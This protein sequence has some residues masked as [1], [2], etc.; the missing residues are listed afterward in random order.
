MKTISCALRGRGGASG[1]KDSWHLVLEVGGDCAF[2]ITTVQKDSLIIEIYAD[3]ESTEAE[4][5]RV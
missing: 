5:E 3:R 4:G 2:N 1:M